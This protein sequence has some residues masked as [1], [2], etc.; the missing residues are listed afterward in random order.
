MMTQ[1]RT[2]RWFAYAAVG[3]V[4]TMA[5]ALPWETAWG[6]PTS[7][8]AGKPAAETTSP[9]PRKDGADQ[10]VNQQADQARD[11]LEVLEA[12]LEAK[13]TLLR[14]AESRMEQAKRWEAHYEKLLRDGKVTEDRLLAA[15]DDVL[16]MDA[17][18]AGERAD[19]KVAEM[20]VKQAR[21]RVAYGEPAMSGLE[22][23]LAEMEQ[24]LAANEVKLDLLQHEVGRLRRDLPHETHGAR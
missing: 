2:L 18:I 15:K 10:K 1:S 20:R 23:R 14:I 12:Q 8:T 5:V 4:F 11:E 16:M 21:R 17:H 6:Q 24:R 9:G 13:R 3:S 19:L 7:P 22:R